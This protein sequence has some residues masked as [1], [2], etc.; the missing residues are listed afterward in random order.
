MRNAFLFVALVGLLAISANL[1]M[2]QATSRPVPKA[3][4]IQR[5]EDDGGN[6]PSKLP[7][8]EVHSA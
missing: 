1:L 2:K 5:W 7:D 4:D 6:L 8:A 3:R